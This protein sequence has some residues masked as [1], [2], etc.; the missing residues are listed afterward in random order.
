[1]INFNTA[2]DS[3]NL[4]INFIQKKSQRKYPLLSGPAKLFFKIKS[5]SLSLIDP[6]KK[7]ILIYHFLMPA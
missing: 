7:Q 5:I 1:M 2:H 4:M 6:P 3:E